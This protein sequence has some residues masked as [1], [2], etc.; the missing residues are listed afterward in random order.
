MNVNAEITI[1]RAY[2]LGP[3]R[4]FRRA[5]RRTL[6]RLLGIGISIRPYYAAAPIGEF[7]PYG[8]VILSLNIDLL[9]VSLTSIGSKVPLPVAPF[10]FPLLPMI[11]AL[12]PFSVSSPLRSNLSVSFSARLQ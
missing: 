12:P 2:N 4:M 8:V 9:L 3:A 11:V 5:I 1:V 7:P 10:H 6:A